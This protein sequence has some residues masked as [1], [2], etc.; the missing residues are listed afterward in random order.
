M[1]PVCD[2]FGEVTGYDISADHR[3]AQMVEADNIRRG[4]IPISDVLKRPSGHQRCIERSISESPEA[5]SP[6]TLVSRTAIGPAAR[7]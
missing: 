4:G 5:R 3:E 7:S 1:A 2:S 6:T